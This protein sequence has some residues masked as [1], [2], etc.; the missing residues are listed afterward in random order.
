VNTLI[1]VGDGLVIAS[2][3]SVLLF[4]LQYTFTSPWWDDPLGF[5]VVAKD[6]ALLIL[7]VPA[8]LLLV[9]PHLLTP[10]GAIIT[11]VTSLALITMTMVWRSV[12]WYRIKKPWPALVMVW[13]RIKELWPLRQRR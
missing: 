13:Y 11:E 6:L 5:T 2:T 1:D 4:V 3:V 9:W 8:S 12:V 7:L 10:L